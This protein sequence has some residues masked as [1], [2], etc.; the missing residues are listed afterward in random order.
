[1]N[2]RTNVR[3]HAMIVGLSILLAG[4][5]GV[6][7]SERIVG[8][9]DGSLDSIEFFSNGDFHQYAL[10]MT[11]KGK[12]NSRGWPSQMGDG[13]TPGHGGRVEIRIG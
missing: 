7:D 2:I 6:T 1:M 3:S 9:W 10:L 4:C 12:W 11:Q 8:R 5:D 13:W